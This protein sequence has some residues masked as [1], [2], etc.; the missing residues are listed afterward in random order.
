MF[1]ATANKTRQGFTLIE[2]LVV[3]AI[4]AI[5][6]AILFPV[7][8][9]VR[10]KARATACL[11]NLNQIAKATIQYNQDYDE[12]FYPHR[13]TVATNGNPLMAQNGGPA[14]AGTI[15]GK[16][17]NRMFWISMLQPYVKSYDVFKCPSNP[18]AWVGGS[19]TACTG[20]GCDGNGYGGENSYGHNDAWLSPAGKYAVDAAG[21]PFTVTLAQV[22]RPT[23]T[24]LMIDATYY[25][26][27]PSLGMGAGD[28]APNYNGVNDPTALANDVAF[29]TD[30][31]GGSATGQYESYWKNI[32]N[33]N[34]SWGGGTLS[35]A[36]A[37][38]LGQNRHTGFVN[39]QFVDGH[40]K[41]LRFEKAITN[42]C[43]WAT[44]QNGAHNACN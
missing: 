42:V 10:E 4:I 43:L 3:I 44:D 23:S 21:T 8:A 17:A 31:D 14:P 39:C 25:G 24:I 9:K 6:A 5:L 22:S 41:A 35:A 2:L 32:G 33:A 40:V 37:M 13:Y 38:T 30:Q 34:W 26:A 19:T 11:S 18:G 20:L 36:Q 1:T 15:T 12:S 28:P 29:F 7:F 16:A 27:N